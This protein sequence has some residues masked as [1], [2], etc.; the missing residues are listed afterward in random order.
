[1]LRIKNYE[2]F[3]TLRKTAHTGELFQLFQFP[4][5]FVVPFRFAIV[6]LVRIR[7]RSVIVM[8][9]MKPAVGRNNANCDNTRQF[10]ELH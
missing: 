3:N 5:K 6:M 9:I 10:P 1:M 7:V 4:A 8:H 2:L